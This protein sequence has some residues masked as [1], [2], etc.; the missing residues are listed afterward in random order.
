MVEAGDLHLRLPKRVAMG[1]QGGGHQV[2]IAGIGQQILVGGRI[3]GHLV[4]GLE[5]DVFSG[6]LDLGFKGV[7]RVDM[8][9]FDGFAAQDHLPQSGG[10]LVGQ[11]P[12]PVDFPLDPLRSGYL[13]HF[14]LVFE[15]GFIDLEGGGQV[16]NGTPFLYGYNTPCGKAAPV[17]YTIHIIDNG[18]G[19]IP[20]PHEIG[21][22]AVGA[23]FGRNG[24][25]GGRQG[26][27]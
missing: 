4:D 2:E 21:V 1:I 5:P 6:R 17:P 26:L 12:G 11:P 3:V 23:S 7:H 24:L 18:L 19:G 16:K 25:A 22:Q 8:A 15:T 13:G 10:Q 14:I 20:R 27:P 9:D